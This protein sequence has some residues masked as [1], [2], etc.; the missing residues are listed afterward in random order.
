MIKLMLQIPKINSGRPHISVYFNRKGYQYFIPKVYHFKL[1]TKVIESLRGGPP[2][3]F[4]YLG[5]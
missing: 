5:L 2:K 1:R 3:A 4:D